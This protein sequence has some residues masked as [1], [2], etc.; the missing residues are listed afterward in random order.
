MP[1]HIRMRRDL[2]APLAP[3]RL[4]AGVSLVPFGRETMR[5]AHELMQR[6]YPEGPNDNGISFDGFWEWLTTD[7]EFDPGLIFIA[8]SDGDVVGLCHCWSVPFIKDL[9]VDPTFRRRGLGTALLTLALQTFRD[10]G[11]ASVDLKTEPGNHEAQSLYRRLG[12][13]EVERVD[14]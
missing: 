4:P 2:A 7:S 5:A 11:S 3:S 10:R 13:V 9:A 1:G 12:F 6:V 14:A 8:A